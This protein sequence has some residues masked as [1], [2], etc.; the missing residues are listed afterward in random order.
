ML[1]RVA[2]G[3]E[4]PAG[5]T[6]RVRVERHRPPAATARDQSLRDARARGDALRPQHPQLASRPFLR[7]FVGGQRHQIRPRAHCHRA[8]PRRRNR[9]LD[10]VVRVHAHSR[11]PVFSLFASHSRANAISPR[12]ASRKSPSRPSGWASAH[13]CRA[14]AHARQPAGNPPRSSPVAHFARKVDAQRFLDGITAAVVTGRYVDPKAGRV[15]LAGFYEPWAAR[16]LWESGTVKAM[17][18]AVR[19]ATFAAVPLWGVRRSHIEAWVKTMAGA[20]LAPGTIHTRV[21]NV[22]SVLRAVRDRVIASD[23]SEGVTLP[24]QRRADVAMELPTPE[25]IGAILTATEDRF[26]ALVAVAAFA[27][28]RLGEA[29]ALRVDDVDFLRRTLAVSWQVQRAGGGQVEVRAPK[30]GSERTVYLADGLVELLARHVE[31]HCPVGPPDR[32]LFTSPEGLPPHQNTVGHQWRQAC[33][34]AGVEGFTLHSCRH[35]Y[36]SGLTA[37][38][39]GVVTVQ[40]ALGHAK[41]TTTL[42]TYSHLW[43][44][45]EDRTRRA[46]SDLIDGVLGGAADYGRTSDPR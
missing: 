5:D 34:R 13:S 4:R 22:R 45:A 2:V 23:P 29:A 15:T 39:C 6:Q 40:R 41:A 14:L 21:V 25:Q 46:A 42:D 20:D 9:P 31:K 17:G 1:Q 18:L 24:R 12:I 36:A 30:F 28:L 38:G 19:S 10:F 35:F 3:L 27:G 26:A 8:G 7:S 37:A 33:R 43:P 11:S 44:T 16:Q 32:W